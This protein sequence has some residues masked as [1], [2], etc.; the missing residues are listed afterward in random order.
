M[1]KILSISDQEFIDSNVGTPRIKDVDITN[2]GTDNVIVSGISVDNPN[3][4]VSGCFP[5]MTNPEISYSDT[6]QQYVNEDGYLQDTDDG[7]GIKGGLGNVSN[8]IDLSFS[9]ASEDMLFQAYIDQYYV[10][11]EVGESSISMKHELDQTSKSFDGAYTYTDTNGLT[12][13]FVSG[14]TR[15]ELQAYDYNIS[16]GFSLLNTFT[17]SDY[18]FAYIKVFENHIAA[19]SPTKAVFLEWSRTGSTVSITKRIA[20]STGGSQVSYFTAV[21]EVD[22]I[23]IIGTYY[24]YPSFF[25]ETYLKASPYTT[26]SASKTGL[27]GMRALSMSADRIYGGHA[28]NV[29]TAF[30]FTDTTITLEASTGSTAGQR[31]CVYDE[32]DK[33]TIYFGSRV[34]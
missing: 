15:G 30:T 7:T 21:E 1:T 10:A 27:S 5:Q 31:V 13:V 25:M 20:K 16:G 19:L 26:T 14:D 11:Y 12:T 18:N 24:N 8:G 34:Y 6:V 33:N 4:I 28:D 9:T 29:L 23:R 17:D 2:S 22:K 32:N 3:F